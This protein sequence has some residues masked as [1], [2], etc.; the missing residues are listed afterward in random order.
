MVSAEDADIVFFPAFARLVSR[1]PFI[2]TV[3]QAV[4]GVTVITPSRARGGPEM[5]LKE[6]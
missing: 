3:G 1:D 2:E 5:R 4:N 6:R